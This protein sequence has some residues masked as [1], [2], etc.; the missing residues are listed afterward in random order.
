MG[1]ATKIE[2]ADRTYNPW[3][4][5]TKV[6]PACEH[7]YAE[8]LSRRRGIKWGPGQPRSRTKTAKDLR[9]WNR[10]AGKLIGAGWPRGRVT[11][12]VFVASLADWLDAEVPVSWLVDLLALIAECE[13]LD[14]LLL[15]KRPALWRGRVKQALDVTGP[16]EQE[17]LDRWLCGTPP[18]NVWIGATV[19]DR[20]R[21][22]ERIPELLE[23]PAQVRFLSSEPLLERLDLERWLS[24]PPWIDWVITGGES[25]PGARPTKAE[26]LRVLRDQCQAARVPF[27]FKGWGEWV[28][29]D[30]LDGSVVRGAR[31]LS[32][33][34]G[35]GAVSVRSGKKAAGR[36]LDGCEWSEVPV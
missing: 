10:S 36:K 17:W 29:V 25:G 8:R 24:G 20:R 35:H 15:S 32:H 28:G 13:Y 7:C 21:A 22:A 26:W 33:D 30:D 34:W 19:E 6:S 12:R 4:G 5:C 11:S 23:I 18:A 3:I 14:F 2:W 16:H 31:M 1:G 27:F 9:R